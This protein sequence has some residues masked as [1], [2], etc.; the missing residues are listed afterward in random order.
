M[1]L[2]SGKSLEAGVSDTCLPQVH[3]RGAYFWNVTLPYSKFQEK[4]S[5]HVDMG[6]HHFGGQLIS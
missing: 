3:L 2:R 1:S 6:E 4:L 5:P